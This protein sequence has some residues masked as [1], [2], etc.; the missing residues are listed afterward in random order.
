[1]LWSRLTVRAEG[2]HD[3]VYPNLNRAN[4]PRITHAP[5]LVSLTE[6]GKPERSGVGGGRRART[7]GRK[8]SRREGG[9]ARTH[10][11]V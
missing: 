5:K 6:V 11:R 2:N 8:R 10:E 1:M 7:A 9:D 3:H 4:S